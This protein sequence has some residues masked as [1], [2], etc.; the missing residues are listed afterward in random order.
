MEGAGGRTPVRQ[1]VPRGELH[2]AAPR[3]RAGHPALSGV[4]AGQGHRA[5]LRRP[6]HA[7]LRAGHPHD[8]RGGAQAAHR[9]ARPRAQ[10]DQEDRRRLGGAEGD[11]G[12]H[13]LP[14]DRRGVH[15][16]RGADLQEV[17]GRIDLRREE[18][19]LPARRR[20]VGH[21]LPHRRQDRPVRRDPARQ[22]G[23]GEGRPAVRA[24][25]GHRP[26]ALLPPRGEA[27]R[28]RG[29]AAPGGHRARHRV[30]RGAGRRARGPGRRPRGRAGEGAPFRG[31]RARHRRLPRAL[32]P[33]RAGPGGAVAAPPP[34]RRGPDARLPG[35][36]LGQRARVAEAAHWR[37]PR[38]RAGGGRQARAQR[39]GRR[40]HRRARLRQVLHRAVHRGAG[41]G[42]E[43]EGRTGR[44]HRPGRQAARRA[45]RR[46][47]VHRAPPAGAE[48]RR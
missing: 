48:A 32:P 35:R 36:G 30:P 10:A 15:L 22:P 43:G 42:Q 25:P 41:A 9:G 14:P 24:V 26:G 27:D 38:A 13:A 4:R 6:D 47:G 40:A 34:H 28:R 1:A 44:A 16:H 18:P 21:R 23:A 19:A 37:R 29:E 12:G 17:R 7:A 33:G 3:H 39:E 5:D 2:D 45:D 8:H 31:R 11:Q 20:C 46:R